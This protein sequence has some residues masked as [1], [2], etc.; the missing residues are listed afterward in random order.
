[1]RV[2][3]TGGDWFEMVRVS[4]GASAQ[5]GQDFDFIW[6]LPE[7]N[8]SFRVLAFDGLNAVQTPWVEGPFVTPPGAVRPNAATFALVRA[9]IL[10]R[11][12]TTVS[13]LDVERGIYQGKFAWEVNVDGTLHYVSLDGI[14]VLDDPLP[15][16]SGPQNARPLGVPYGLLVAAAGAAVGGVF[17]ARRRKRRGS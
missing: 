3:V 16:T 7:G 15:P 9:T 17:L 1:V 10:D 6:R 5:S 2:Q 8:H 14:E 4:P 11:Y 13:P 12:H